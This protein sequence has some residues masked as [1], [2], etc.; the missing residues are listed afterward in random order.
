MSVL[1][2]LVERILNGDRRAVARAIS[3]I[4]DN[5]PEKT[6]ILQ[7][8]FPHTGGAFLLGITGS[9]GAGKS[10]FVD[11]LIGY[12]RKQGL[13]I[14]IVAVDPTSPFTGGAIL[15][16]RIRM[17]DHFL[18]E[19]VFIRSMGTRGSLG[20]LARATKEAVRVL[21]A[22]GKDIVIIETVG[23][24]QS[25]LDIMNIADSTAVVLNPGGGDT[26]QAFKAGIMEIADLFILNKA[27]LAGTDKLFREVEQ[28]LDLVKHDSPWRPPVVK[29]ITTQGMGIDEAW[30][31]FLDH[32]SY[33]QESKEWE[34]RRAS[35]LR[36]EVS[37]I[38]EHAV[39]QLIVK[40]LRSEE[41]KDMMEGV[42]RR[43]IDP[44]EVA[45]QLLQQLVKE[46]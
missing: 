46:K 14:G 16:D 7:D 2:A 1:H 37:E 12:L 18:D 40:R 38:V 34:R 26:V 10:S 3:Y 30:Q 17:Q 22:Y 28:M 43:D 5:H 44:Y 32:K 25:E 11:K 29:T 45:H 19:G 31:A 15:G 42:S 27:D 4:E 41:Y 9:P 8:L 6:E 20:G 39:H 36:E 33:L 24:G 35:H 13:T 23:V 21:D